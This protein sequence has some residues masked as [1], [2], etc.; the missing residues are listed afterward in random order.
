RNLIERYRTP[1]FELIVEDRRQQLGLERSVVNRRRTFQR[2]YGGDAAAVKR[3][4]HRLRRI[5]PSRM[6]E[7]PRVDVDLRQTGNV[8]AGLRQRS[9]LPV[10][11]TIEFF[12]EIVGTEDNAA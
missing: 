2:D 9:D 12:L 7:R 11:E 10:A 6:R 8:V 5:L 4:A 1:V 3:D